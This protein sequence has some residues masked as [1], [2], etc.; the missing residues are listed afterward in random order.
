MGSDFVFE[1]VHEQLHRYYPQWHLMHHCCDS[2]TATSGLIFDLPDYIFEFWAAKS[3][4]IAILGT[5]VFG[6]YDGFACVVALGVAIAIDICNHDA[7]CRTP[8]YDHHQHISTSYGVWPIR[9]NSA[10]RADALDKI[11]GLLD[12]IFGDLSVKHVK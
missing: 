6:C 8:H 1:R 2:P 4:I 11:H 10:S 3:P 7:W 5:N 9:T 12:A